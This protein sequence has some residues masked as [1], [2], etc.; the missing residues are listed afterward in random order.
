[1]RLFSGIDADAMGPY[2]LCAT[3]GNYLHTSSTAKHAGGA[4]EVAW[5]TATWGPRVPEPPHVYMAASPQSR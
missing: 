4:F 1:M 5:A 3:D 2:Q